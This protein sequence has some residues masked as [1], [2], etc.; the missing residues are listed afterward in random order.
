MRCSLI[1]EFG[2][3]DS[4]KVEEELLLKVSCEHSVHTVEPPV[5]AEYK[6]ISRCAVD[7]HEIN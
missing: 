7:M 5:L 3:H 4:Q 1:P 6:H 2:G